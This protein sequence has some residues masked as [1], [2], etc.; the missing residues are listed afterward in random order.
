MSLIICSECGK[1][2]SDRASACPNCACPNPCVDHTKSSASESSTRTK[3]S[4][5]PIIIT[6]IIIALMVVAIGYI[7]KVNLYNRGIH[8]LYAGD[9]STAR[10]CLEDLNY[11]DSKLVMNDI[12]FL[13]ELEEIV[14]EEISYD[15]EMEYIMNAAEGN[16]KKIRKYKAKEF[17][18]DGLNEMIDRYVEG[19]ERIIASSNYESDARGQYEFLA[20]K[21]YCDYA[22][23]T[24]HDSIGFMQNSAKY[25]EVYTDIISEENAMLTAFE[26]L[27][28]KGHV[29]ARD[30]EF[31]NS[32]VKLHLR[33]D[34]EYKFDQTYVFNFYNY[35]GDKLLETVTVDVLGIEP[36]AEYTVCIDVPRS[37]RNGYSVD[38]SYYYLHIDIPD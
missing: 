38:Y 35:N 4:F 5:R 36:Y 8:A 7:H 13:E 12:A 21:Y 32:T 30:G 19:L 9:Y 6:I 20:G 18:T 31:R 37:A 10:N 11:K 23:V 33:N 22:V 17:Y 24:S 3:Y 15:S 34:T 1:E 25:A 14:N 2:Y 27:F 29:V 28:E 16:L 26:E